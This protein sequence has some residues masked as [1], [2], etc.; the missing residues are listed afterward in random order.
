[1]FNS[2]SMLHANILLAKTLFHK[3]V[4]EVG[5]GLAKLRAGSV[6]IIPRVYFESIQRFFKKLPF[7]GCV[8]LSFNLV[9]RVFLAFFNNFV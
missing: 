9:I 2:G 1:M 6:S 3:I 5:F 8:L 4:T 7:M